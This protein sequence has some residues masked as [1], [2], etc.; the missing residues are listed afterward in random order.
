MRTITRL[1]ISRT[2]GI[3]DVVL[4]LPIAGLLKKVHPDCEI[5]FV[6]RT[7]TQA[8]ISACSHVDHFINWD[9]LSALDKQAQKNSIAGIKADAVV[10]VFPNKAFA[11]I[12]ANARIPLRIGTSH[13]FFHWLTCNK[14]V[15]L[16][17]KTSPWHEAQLNAQLCRSL[18]IKNIP[19]LEDLAEMTGLSMVPQLEEPHRKLLATDRFNLI[20]HP[21]SKGSAREWG[22][23]N[24]NELIRL[25]PKDRYKIFIS[26]TREDG[27]A[28]QPVFEQWGELVTNITGTMSLPEFISFIA[29]A[30]GLVAASTGPLHIAAALGKVA[31][32]LYAPMRP[33]H[34]GRWSPIG[35][36]AGFLVQNKTCQACRKS[37]RCE[38]IESIRPADVVKKIESLS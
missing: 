13:R 25:L 10:H 5:W 21:K 2:D 3:G 20:L 22:I 19:T 31:V 24:F 8:V 36:K 17:R 28:L 15:N 14:L 4:T 37:N 33:I 18:G 11:R 35:I 9:D 16:S 34:P 1:I 27:K 26:G 6:G 30:D 23:D 7:Y 32:G 29:Q 12:C 38:C